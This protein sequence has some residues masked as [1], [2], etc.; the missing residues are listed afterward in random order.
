MEKV[1]E[2]LNSAL[3]IIIGKKEMGFADKFEA[4]GKEL[5]KEIKD[6]CNMIL[7]ATDGG[8][9]TYINIIGNTRSLSVILAYTAIKTEGFDKVL[10]NAVKRIEI[11]KEKHNK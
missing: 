2:V 4:A 6:G 9:E 11:Y 5:K 1:K 3:S 10:A 7:I 8:D